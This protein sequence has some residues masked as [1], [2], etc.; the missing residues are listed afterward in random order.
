M[1]MSCI[2]PVGGLTPPEKRFINEFVLPSLPLAYPPYGSPAEGGQ[3]SAV[4]R[5]GS[6][7]CHLFCTTLPTRLRHSCLPG[8]P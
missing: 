2:L 7:S 6:C 4:P 3:P 8:D 1:R 5:V